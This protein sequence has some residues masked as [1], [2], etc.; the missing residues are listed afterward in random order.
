Q[1]A[2]DIQPNYDNLYFYTRTLLDAGEVDKALKVSTEALEEA[3]KKQ[4]QEAIQIEGL[5]KFIQ[6]K[7][8][9]G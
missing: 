4:G 1:E 6:S 3:K 8:D 2:Y 7:K 9:N 5:V